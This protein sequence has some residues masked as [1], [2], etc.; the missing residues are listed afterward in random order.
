[1]KDT[2]TPPPLKRPSITPQRT[3][4][5]GRLQKNDLVDGHGPTVA[6]SPW[7]MWWYQVRRVFASISGRADQKVPQ[8]L[9]ADPDHLDTPGH[10][11]VDATFGKCMSFPRFE[12]VLTDY[13]AVSSARLPGL[14]EIYE[15]GCSPMLA[16]LPHSPREMRRPRAR[17]MLPLTV[18]DQGALLGQ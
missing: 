11:F 4:E 15:K 12:C 8:R 3:K 18:P 14:C 10:T 9:Q 5:S 7:V 6:H 17:R 16:L 13:G 1:M 2:S